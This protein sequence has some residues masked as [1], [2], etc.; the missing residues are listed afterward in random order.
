MLGKL[1]AKWAWNWMKNAGKNYTFDRK[2]RCGCFKEFRE[3]I[4]QRSKNTKKKN[5]VNIKKQWKARIAIAM[6]SW[7]F[8]VH[9][10][11]I[12]AEWNL[13]DMNFSVAF[14]RLF[15]SFSFHS[16]WHFM[17]RHEWW[18]AQMLSF[19]NIHKRMYK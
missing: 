18:W 2:K 3:H 14:I 17:F 15:F 11:T 12:T 9:S 4:L 6:Q 10:S 8:S 13:I 1:I 7:D 16:I 5:N 19:I